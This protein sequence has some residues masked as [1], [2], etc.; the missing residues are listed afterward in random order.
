VADALACGLIPL[1]SDKVNI[2]PDVAGDGA[3]LVE[4]DT[5]DGTR[6]LIER[7]LTMSRTERDA[8]RQRGLACYQRRYALGNAANEVYRAMGLGPNG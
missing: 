8:M 3:G 2:A 1:I 5:L 7:F 6:R 4:S